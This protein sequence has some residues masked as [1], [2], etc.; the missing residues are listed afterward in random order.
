MARR[1]KPFGVHPARVR[2]IAG[3]RENL[4]HW[5]AEVYQAGVAVTIWSGWATKDE[6]AAETRQAIER[7]PKHRDTLPPGTTVPEQPTVTDLVEHWV[8]AMKKR[9]DVRAT[10]KTSYRAH[11]KRLKR[12]MGD[13]RL[14]GL[15]REVLDDYRDQRLGMGEATG[16]VKQDLSVLEVALRWGRPRGFHAPEVVFPAIEVKPKRAKH[17]PMPEEVA[18][19]YL[20]MR[21]GWPRM[22]F[23]L[24]WA[25]GARIGE[26][27]MLTWADIDLE[28]GWV[29]VPIE[30]KTGARDVP[31]LEEEVVAEL[32]EWME[33]GHGAEG[34]P[35]LG[36]A[37]ETVRHKLRLHMTDAAAACDPPVRR[38]TAK[39]LRAAAVDELARAKV[40]IKTACAL[41]GHSEQVMIAYY[42]QATNEDKRQ[43]MRDAGL[44]RLPEGVF[45][46]R[47]A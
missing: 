22:A 39:A 19:V 32:R 30:T 35:L 11:A 21:E 28:H 43:A 9:G 45:R 24:L 47:K 36:V 37:V 41:T 8:P 16:T 40:D 7:P 46:F 6:A 38:F 5:R 29:R 42:R 14:S 2:C 27:A 26:V 34:G 13:V 20:A 17:T 15:R 12:N 44:G 25:T 31:L 33:A 23:R 4:W 1:P 18:R 10:T 3:P